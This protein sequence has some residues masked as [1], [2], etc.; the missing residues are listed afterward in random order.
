MLASLLTVLLQ[1]ALTKKCA[2]LVWPFI[3][4]ENAA[5][6]EA[7]ARRIRR[8]KAMAEDKA[9]RAALKK[10]RQGKQAQTAIVDDMLQAMKSR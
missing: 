5:R 1:C 9:K 8:E 3:L 2:L 4:Q 10:E 6:R 7:E